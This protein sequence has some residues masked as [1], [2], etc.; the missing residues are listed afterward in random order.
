MCLILL[1]TVGEGLLQRSLS[2]AA[3]AVS[4]IRVAF[5]GNLQCWLSWRTEV[6][7]GVGGVMATDMV[8]PWWSLGATA[9]RAS[10]CC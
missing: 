8:L 2:R 10:W 4:K 5:V 3:K 9:G 6:L 1:Q 7:Q